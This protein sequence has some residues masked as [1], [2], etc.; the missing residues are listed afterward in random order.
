MLVMSTVQAG[1]GTN[2][3]HFLSQSAIHVASVIRTCLD[4]DIATIEATPEAEEE[5][6]ATLYEV[7]IGLAHYSATCIPGYYN[8]EGAT[9]GKGAR[10]LV[11]P[12]SLLHYAGYLE[13]WRDA[14]DMPGARVVRA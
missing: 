2:F 12:G 13:R 10:N 9:S 11:Y 8:S 7:A 14:G 3:V 5:W 1:F 4:E 6:L